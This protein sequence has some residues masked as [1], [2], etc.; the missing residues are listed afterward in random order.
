M[1]RNY[2]KI[3]LRN[4][5]KDKLHT[6]INTVGLSLGIAC[7]ILILLFVQNELSF[8]RFHSKSD[9]LY[10][11]WVLEEYENGNQFFNTVTPYP[12][13]PALATEV[14]E[15]EN[16][17]QISILNWQADLGDKKFKERVHM[18]GPA[19]FE[20]FDFKVIAGSASMALS[21]VKNIV[22]TEDAA[23]KY[24][25][26]IQVVGNTMEFEVDDGRRTYEVAAVVENAPSNSSIKFDMLISDL[27]KDLLFG[28]MELDNWFNVSAETYVLL[29]E[30]VNIT[31]IEAKLANISEKY[32]GM[33]PGDGKYN[34]GLQPMTD[35]HLNPEYPIGIAPL[36]D[37]KYSYIL[38]G[39]ALLI[40]FIACINFIMLSIS[41]SVGRAL[42]VGVRK[43]IGASKLQIAQQFLSEAIL[44]VFLGL[45]FGLIL[46]RLFLSKFNELSNKVLE[47]GLTP[48]L[49][50][51][52]FGLVIVIGIIAG[53]YPAFVVS[54]FKSASIL[55]GGITGQVQNS[56]LRRILIGVQFTLSIG[57]IAS[58]LIMRDQ[59]NYLKNRNLGFDKEQLV[60][61]P[62]HVPDGRITAT[63]QKGME[64]AQLYTSKL[65]RFP[66]IKSV[67]VS[68]HTFSNAG[69][70][71]LGYS[72]LEGMYHEFNLNVVSPEYISTMAMQIVK[73]RDFQ[74]GNVADQQMAVIVNEAFAKAFAIENL[75]DAKI[76]GSPF[77]EHQ[78][79]GVVKDFNYAS[80][81][82]KIQPLAMTLNPMIFFTNNINMNFYSDPTPKLFVKLEGDKISEGLE[83]LQK[84][85]SEISPDETFEF[86]FIDEQ[87]SAMYKQEQN[88]GTIVGIAALFT[89]LVGSLGLFAL[90]S[91]NI[92]NRMKELSIRSI[93]GA[94][95]GIRLYLI[96]KEYIFMLLGA[97]LISTPIAWYVMGDWLAGFAYRIPLSATFFLWAGLIA[98]ITSALS[99]GYHANKAV[100]TPPVEYLRNE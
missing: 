29:K 28:A 71:E 39:I 74:E 23:I 12:L 30:D 9:R 85:W 49:L 64:K 11:A 48:F 92:Q 25:G 66:Q 73:G 87:I 82:G 69:W 78:I 95:E 61:V 98:L 83:V 15:I 16:I 86:Q 97:L 41:K 20:I 34:I 51:V 4:L 6:V 62:L 59:L 90:V 84:T 36:S 19:F 44:T 24:F 55:K 21:D 99:I 26:N 63:I 77:G 27:N 80:L 94:S 17:V 67:A 38:G 58:T 2:I 35:I 45:L 57:L 22:L 68:S 79:I 33:P 72:D 47:M 100:K 81:H 65:K 31:G 56:T 43:S 40:L 50:L 93:L 76:E 70:T 91:L 37:P 60:S 1:L 54:N 75:N 5:R 14:P 18:V 88:L 13:A 42:E 53:S 96:S 8:D 3:A 32:V 89:I 52:C 10:R 7:C 46:A